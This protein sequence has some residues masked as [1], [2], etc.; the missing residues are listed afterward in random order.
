MLHRDQT[1]LKSANIYFYYFNRMSS[2]SADSNISVK[3]LRNRAKQ[4]GLGGG[5]DMCKSELIKYINGTGEYEVK[6]IDRR[7]H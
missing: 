3:E 6:P 5:Y 1:K 4:L 7:K 2:T